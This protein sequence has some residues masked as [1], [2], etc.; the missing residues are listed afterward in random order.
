MKGNFSGKRGRVSLVS[1]AIVIMIIVT[2][3][4]L[5]G[6]AKDTGGDTGSGVSNANVSTAPANNQINFLTGQEKSGLSSSFLAAFSRTL[7]K[8]KSFTKDKGEVSPSEWL[9]IAETVGEVLFSLSEKLVNPDKPNFKTVTNQLNQ[10]DAQIN[11]LSQ[12]AAQIQVQLATAQVDLMEFMGNQ[13]TT[14]QYVEP[15]NTYFSEGTNNLINF[16]QNAAYFD[17]SPAPVPTPSVP[18]PI[19][20]PSPY[21]TPAFVPAPSLAAV[22]SWIAPYAANVMNNQTVQ[23]AVNGIATQ[24]N[25]NKLLMNYVNYLIL[26][27]PSQSPSPTANPTLNTGFSSLNPNLANP[28]NV[29]S[30]Y[31]LLEKYFLML[32]TTQLKGLAVISNADLAP[33][34]NDPTGSLFQDYINQTFK[35]ELYLEIQSF[36]QA[37]DY[38]SVN[39]YDYR[40]Q[41]QFNADCGSIN[42][43]GLV[44]DTVYFQVL[45]RSRFV[46]AQL[47]DAFGCNADGLYGT[48]IVPSHY[49]SSGQAI[50]SLGISVLDRRGL[51]TAT[52]SPINQKSI[53]PYTWWNGNAAT[54]DNTWAVFDY[55]TYDPT[56]T[57]SQQLLQGSYFQNTLNTGEYSNYFVD[58]GSPTSPWNHDPSYIVMNNNLQVMYYCPNGDT[59]TYPPTT[60]LTPQNTQKFGFFAYRWY[61]GYPKFISSPL[62]GWTAS[63]QV[64]FPIE[65]MNLPHYVYSYNNMN[66]EAY[67]YNTTSLINSSNFSQYFNPIGTN[68]TTF[69]NSIGS[70][71]STYMSQ[72]ERFWALGYT[73]GMPFTVAQPPNG[74]GSTVDTSFFA[75]FNINF[76]GTVNDIN[77]VVYFFSYVGSTYLLNLQQAQQYSNYTSNSIVKFGATPNTTY[78]LYNT[79]FYMTELNSGAYQNS[80]LWYIQLVFNGYVNIFN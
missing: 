62:S 65:Q 47:L 40:N 5:N 8:K 59:T 63:N 6:C 20:S 23:T 71:Y 49:P 37:V 54:M 78:N 46:S 12:E 64:Q 73:L 50:T 25:S 44:G 68:D 11:Q 4:M 75:N 16:S 33:T 70:S 77:C 48:V 10:L 43:S 41:D 7:C 29:M 24:I 34:S 56:F 66:P 26:N 13:Y 19:P 36:L 53:Y 1:K 35:P 18:F 61:W 32:Y 9:K 51:A 31:L 52:Q 42:K 72:N 74:A 69:I 67:S 39:L 45:A 27:P 14:G 3:F 76:S 38:L 21:P 17:P 55:N 57:P 2:A 58:N 22:Q 60:Y 80:M 15:I 79:I 30:A 28:S